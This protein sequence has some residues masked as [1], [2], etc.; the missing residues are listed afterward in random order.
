MRLLLKH[1][2]MVALLAGSAAHAEFLDR[3]DLQPAIVSGFVSHHIDPRQ[4][5]NENN[6]GIGYRF[7][8]A[9]VIVGYYHNSHYKGSVYAAYEAR[10][11]LA[12]NIHAGLLAGGVTGYKAAVSPFVLP[13]LVLQ[14]YRLELA[15]TYVPS[16]TRNIPS[17]V[18][19]QARWGF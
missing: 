14:V 5:Y 1:L 10:W 2:T 6:Y 15:T 17:L 16:V 8:K 9:D 7:G 4:H 11:Q 18:A 12:E 19:L 3:V 13:E